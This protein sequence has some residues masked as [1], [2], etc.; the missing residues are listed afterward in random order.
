M[1]IFFRCP[2]III[3]L[4]LLAERHIQAFVTEHDYENKSKH[5]QMHCDVTMQILPFI[6]VSQWQ[7]EEMC[8]LQCNCRV[9]VLS[10]PPAEPPYR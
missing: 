10:L 2:R 8:R 9:H 4:P 7:I 6:V 3:I 5:V 1:L